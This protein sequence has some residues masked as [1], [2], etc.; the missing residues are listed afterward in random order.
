MPR[1]ILYV[2]K[3]F[4]LVRFYFLKLWCMKVGSMFSLL[5]WLLFVQ[6]NHNIMHVGLTIIVM[7]DTK[8]CLEYALQ[9]QRWSGLWFF[10]INGSE[11]GDK[12]WGK[13]KLS[14]GIKLQKW[15]NLMSCRCWT[16][17]SFFLF[18]FFFFGCF[19]WGLAVDC[20]TL[21]ESQVEKSL[22]NRSG[23]NEV[24]ACLTAYKVSWEWY[25]VVI[26]NVMLA[27]LYHKKFS[28]LRKILS[29]AWEELSCGCSEV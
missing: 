29:I 18:S 21:R 19:S 23:W 7:D 8:L 17:I 12:K 20:I 11:I 1:N 15:W 27:L 10:M 14:G 25:I 4:F 5:I 9:T 3:I 6:D 28:Q 13:L 26:I 16:G 24:L 2:F 22:V